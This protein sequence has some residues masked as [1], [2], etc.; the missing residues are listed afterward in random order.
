MLKLLCRF[1]SQT[2]SVPCLV[3][4]LSGSEI[5]ARLG[6]VSSTEVYKPLKASHFRRRLCRCRVYNRFNRFVGRSDSFSGNHVP[7]EFDFADISA[8]LM[9]NPFRESSR[10][11]SRSV[12]RGLFGCDHVQ[13][14]HLI[15]S[16]PPRCREI[17]G[18][19]VLILFR[20][21]TNTEHQAS[22]PVEPLVRHEGSDISRFLLELNLVISVF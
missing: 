15:C 14:Y 16:V 13:R 21:R 20:S 4:F 18:N 19:D 2:N 11:L 5:V 1:G 7:H 3:S 17:L 12:R 10:V 6:D 8:G 22:I 9:S